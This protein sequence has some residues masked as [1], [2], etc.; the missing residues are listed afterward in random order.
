MMKGKPWTPTSLKQVGGTEGIGV[1]FLEETFSSPTA[2]PKHR[3]HQKAA[4]AVLKALLPES[5]TDIKGH[6]RSQ[7]ALLE[8]SGYGS[9]PKDFDGFESTY[10]RRFD[11]PD[12]L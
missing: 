9:R 6:M 5:G 7:Q 2:N 10:R 12:Y 4:R 11:R 3:L 8:A 1:T